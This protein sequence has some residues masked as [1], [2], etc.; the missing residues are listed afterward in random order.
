MS[1]HCS[2]RGPC[3]APRAGAE[4]SL[5]LCLRCHLGCC[6]PLFQFVLDF[7]A[8]PAVS[9]VI[10]HGEAGILVHRW[11]ECKMV[12]LPWESWQFPQNRKQRRD[13]AVPFRAH[14]REEVKQGCEQTSARHPCRPRKGESAGAVGPE[15]GRSW[16]ACRSV[17]RDV[18]PSETRPSRED[19]RRPRPPTQVRRAARVLRHARRGS[20]G[21]EAWRAVGGGGGSGKVPE[22]AVLMPLGCAFKSR[23]NGKFCVLFVSTTI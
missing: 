22:A 5:L 10:V 9:S 2:S 11:R 8:F 14:A 20:C 6:D 1:L 23:Q 19:A 18:V 3:G 12:R 13:L 17:R 16:P 15:P 21:G 7:R 4:S